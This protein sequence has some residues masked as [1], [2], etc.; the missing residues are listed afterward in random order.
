MNIQ[1]NSKFT[2]QL[3]LAALTL[4]QRLGHAAEGAASYYFPGAAG[5]FAVAVAPPGGFTLVNQTVIYNAR[6]SR[7]VLS[8]RA[9]A[10]LEV[11]AVYNYT[12]G[13]YSVTPVAGGTFAMGGFVPFGHM[14]IK[15][16]VTGP[17]GATTRAK[18]SD[19]NIGDVVLVP[20]SLH[21]NNKGS[22]HFKIAQNIVAPTGHY[23]IDSR[24]NVGR[25]YW[26][27]DTN[28]ALTYLNMKRG[29]ET[30]IA[31]GVQFNLKNP[32]TDYKTG[33]EFHTD[34]MINQFLSKN[35]A[36]GVHAYYYNQFTADSGSGAVLGAFQGKA[37]GWGPA[38]LWSPKQT[39]GKL[40]ITAKWMQDVHSKNRL[41][42]SYAAIVVAFKL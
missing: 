9:V 21:W 8:G 4:G 2:I 10:D 24:A 30:S 3:L 42:A 31:P 32:D 14:A 18:V 12:G 37:F 11:N 36:L 28:A 39:A 25:N 27:F 19:F 1:R 26:A 41:R 33:N 38:L 7:A 22:V 35:F 20:A 29:F 17:N 23:N 13:L 5:S 40:N 15:G 16:I 6:T 34:F